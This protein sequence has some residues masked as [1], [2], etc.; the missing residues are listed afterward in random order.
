VADEH[1]LSV[2]NVLR[3]RLRDHE[4]VLCAFDLI[5]VDDEDLRWRPLEVRKARLAKLLQAV[6]DGIAFNQHFTGDGAIIFKH[7]CELGC[8][9]IVSK[10]IGSHYRSGR[11]DHW[12]K[13]KNPSSAGSF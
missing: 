10:R 12:L 8:E 9:G 13:I 11:V 2:F 3:W 5:A 7:A 4:A 6:P 1:G